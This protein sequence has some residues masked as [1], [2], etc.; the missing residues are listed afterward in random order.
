MQVCRFGNSCLS[1]VPSTT[2][3]SKR[4]RSLPHPLPQS[5]T[6]DAVLLAAHISQ[7][8]CH[9]AL[10]AVSDSTTGLPQ[11]QYAIADRSSPSRRCCNIKAV[12][13]QSQLCSTAS[14]ALLAAPSPALCCNL[15]P[16]EPD[17]A[18]PRRRS[19][20]LPVAVQPPRPHRSCSTPIGAAIAL[21]V[22]AV[23]RR[24]SPR[25]LRAVNPSSLPRRCLLPDVVPLSTSGLQGSKKKRNRERPRTGQT[26]KA[27]EKSAVKGREFHGLGC[28]L[29]WA[30]K[31][32]LL[33]ELHRKS[34]ESD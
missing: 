30:S 18:R 29:I 21:S 3:A 15:P 9:R 34:G 19:N 20:S 4:R 26:R 1:A 8:R 12:R 24:P 14:P 11:I 27:R 31:P 23:R 32:N 6:T 2:K 10:P 13:A 25:R 16:L 17:A 22:A 7:R 5:F 28:F 33:P